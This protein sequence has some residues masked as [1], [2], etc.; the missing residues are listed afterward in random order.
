MQPRLRAG[1]QGSRWQSWGIGLI[2]CARVF[3]TNNSFGVNVFPSRPTLDANLLGHLWKRRRRAMTLTVFKG[4]PMAKGCENS[5]T[6]LVW[7]E[8]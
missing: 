1:E 5:S 6:E 7:V 8:R 2:C 4:V 3:Q